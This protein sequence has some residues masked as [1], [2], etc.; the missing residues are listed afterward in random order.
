LIVLRVAAAPWM[1]ISDEKHH[2][3][4]ALVFAGGLAGSYHK[5]AGFLMQRSS[6]KVYNFVL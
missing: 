4:F 1:L 2:K 6:G 3:A 5:Q